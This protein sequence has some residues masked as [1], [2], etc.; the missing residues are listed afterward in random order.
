[1]VLYLRSIRNVLESGNGRS[2]GVLDL[3]MADYHL[4]REL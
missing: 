4:G 3:S 1:M 2:L